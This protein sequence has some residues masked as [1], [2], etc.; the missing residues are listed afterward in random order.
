MSTE[1]QYLQ[2][3]ENWY[4]RTCR[5]R[6]IWQDKTQP[7]NVKQKAFRLWSIMF[8]RTLFAAKNQ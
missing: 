5:L 1:K 4:Q 3:V 7:E 6:Q 2:S 8:E